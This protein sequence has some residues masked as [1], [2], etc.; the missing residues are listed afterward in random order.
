MAIRSGDM[1]GAR[2]R[3]R[4]RPVGDEARRSVGN[5]R[6]C[7]LR[8]DYASFPEGRSLLPLSLEVCPKGAREMML[9]FPHRGGDA[10]QTRRAYSS[11]SIAG[12]PRCSTEVEK[13]I[14]VRVRPK[15]CS[16]LMNWSSSCV[17]RK[18]TLMSME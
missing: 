7:R 13:T 10:K 5:R 12:M 8:H 16:W 17:V 15:R 1:R 3:S 4:S 2:D 9:S 18:Q 6:E 11:G 14:C